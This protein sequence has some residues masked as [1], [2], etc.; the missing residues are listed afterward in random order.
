MAQKTFEYYNSNIPD[1]GDTLVS[2]S[3]DPVP[4]YFEKD[5]TGRPKWFTYAA[6]DTDLTGWYL[7]WQPVKGMVVMISPKDH[8]KLFNYPWIQQVEILRRTQN[9]KALVGRLLD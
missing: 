2:L 6:I 9:E 4:A 5:S 1:K 7:D 8:S 3:R